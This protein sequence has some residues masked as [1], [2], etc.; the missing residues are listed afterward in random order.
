MKA[1]R[2]MAIGFQET[3]E[4]LMEF[5]D[6]VGDDVGQIGVLGLVPHV[7]DGIKVRGVCWKPFDT[8]P[9][10]TVLQQLPDSGTMGRQT[11]THENERTPQ[12]QVNLAQEPNKVRS[13]CVVVKEF[14]VQADPTGPGRGRS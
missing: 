10:S 8:K 14:I 6:I 5:V 2:L 11:V 9:W 12:V 13:S 3:I 7:F 4:G 1:V